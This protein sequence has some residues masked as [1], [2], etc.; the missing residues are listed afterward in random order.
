ML[1]LLGTCHLVLDQVFSAHRIDSQ[2]EEIAM[3]LSN[4]TL[5]PFSDNVRDPDEPNHHR[6]H[7]SRV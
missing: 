5:Q 2:L 6:Q 3:T 7:T 4:N 1:A